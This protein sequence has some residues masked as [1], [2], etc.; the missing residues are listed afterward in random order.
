MTAGLGFLTQGMQMAPMVE[1]LPT[2]GGWESTVSRP[3]NLSSGGLAL[4][5][6]R[7]TAASV[8]SEYASGTSSIIDGVSGAAEAI[9]KGDAEALEARGRAAAI[10]DELVRTVA[11]QRVAF[12]GSGVDMSSG[13]PVTIQRETTRTGLRNAAVEE[14]NVSLKKIKG[15]LAASTSLTQ[16]L[17]KAGTAFFRAGMTDIGHRLSVAK[18]G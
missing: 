6:G 15:Q 11:R 13:T 12:A 3:A 17:S 4:L 9:L 8:L 18:R 7:A 1:Q 5:E 14:G 2:V 16:G 10:R